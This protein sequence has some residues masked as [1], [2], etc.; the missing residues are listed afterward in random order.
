MKLTEPINS[1]GPAKHVAQVLSGAAGRGLWGR[2]RR[3]LYVLSVVDE[4]WWTDQDRRL[5]RALARRHRRRLS[6][7]GI[8]EGWL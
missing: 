1:G 4:K 7:L 5:M 2:T 3:R 6:A 8:K